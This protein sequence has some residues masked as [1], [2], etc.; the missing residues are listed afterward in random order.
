MNNKYEQTPTIYISKW[1]EISF[2]TYAVLLF[3]GVKP[4]NIYANNFQYGSKLDFIKTH[5]I[6]TKWLK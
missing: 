3:K 2:K 4:Q 5:K 6:E 1:Y